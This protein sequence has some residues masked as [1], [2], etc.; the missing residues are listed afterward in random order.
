MAVNAFRSDG[1][2]MPSSAAAAFML[3]TSSVGAKARSVSARSARKRLGCQPTH[4]RAH[5]KGPL[6]A[7]GDAAG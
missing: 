6:V 1:Q 3:P 4:C 2:V 5:A 7:A